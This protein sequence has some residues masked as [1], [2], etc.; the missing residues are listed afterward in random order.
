MGKRLIVAEKKSVGQ[1]I[2]KTLKCREKVD[3]A[4]KGDN[5]IVTWARGHLVELCNPE[6]LDDKY[7]E[8]KSEDLPILPD[9]FRLQVAKDG[10]KQFNI[11]KA[12]MLD[13][14]IDSVVCATDA[15]R[16]GE[17]IFRYIYKLAGCTKPVKR[18]WI[19]SLTYS[20]IK[21][22]F[23]EL[24]DSSEY[25]DLYQ[26]ARCRAEADWLVGMNG[27]RAFAIAN[28]KRGLSVG[29]V[30]SP[31]LAI[32]VDREL[33]RRNFKPEEYC[34]LIIS[35]DGWE[36]RMIN[37]DNNDD[38]EKWSRFPMN[39]KADLQAFASVQHPGAKVVLS[40]SIEE[41]IPPLQL[42]D[43]T[44]LQRDANRLYN[45]SS[46]FTLD[47]AQSLYEKKAITYPRTDSRC[48]SADIK[49]TLSKRL[50]SLCS[51][52]WEDYA[53]KAMH[54]EKDLFGRFIWDKGVSDHHAIIP[55]GEAKELEKWSKGEQNIYDL[56]AR[57]FIG[58]FFTDRVV[59][60]QKVIT[61]IDDK[62]FLSFGEK[63]VADGW[64]AV[65]HSRVSY[66][67]ELPEVN[68]GDIVCVKGLRVRT[69]QTKPPAPHTEASL[70]NAMEHAGKTIYDETLEDHEEEYG[71]GTPATRADIIEKLLEKQMATRKGRALIPTEYGIRLVEILP[72][73]MRSPEMTSEWEARLSH[74]SRGSEDP[75]HFMSDIRKMTAELVEYAAD[76]GNRG[77]KDAN[78][79]GK[80]PLCGQ[81]VRE[82]Q[83]AYYCENKECSFRGIWKAKKGFHP[84]LKSDTMKE[85]LEKGVA[86]TDKG[87]YKII[88]SEP[89]ISFER[90]EKPEP[91]YES[92]WK[93]ITNYGLKPINKV[94]NGGALWFEGTRGD[95]TLKDFASDCTDIGCS[96]Q[97]ANDARALKHKSG[98]YLEVKP[99]HLE[100]FWN[101]FGQKAETN[102]EGSVSPTGSDPFLDL[103]KGSGFEYIDKR[104]K[105]GGLWIVA[106]EEEAK[107]FVKECK[108]KGIIWT[109]A[110]NG[111]RSTKHKPGWY[112]R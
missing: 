68:E 61:C 53:A 18:L 101:V 23:E 8:W 67:K 100:A 55:T 59:K 4:I 83:D 41:A 49:S 99:E 111:S 54:S 5:Y 96:L 104:E 105:K 10:E 45:Y 78:V 12:W 11:V 47:M 30:T 69:D 24:K 34:E 42:Y 70:L 1:E 40:D 102:K 92:L 62:E 28:E 95:E 22:G 64:S 9:L 80:C 25:D 48:L 21:K 98:W 29:R 87:T 38:P 6:D 15:G 93:L 17:L 3:G 66:V 32:L 86:K 94:L 85:L 73:Y 75:E 90:A 91:D 88:S 52:M 76:Q 2:A 77:L 109:F 108:D 84:T 31:T 36:G 56:I 60:R 89:Y 19:S 44:S 110:P 97:F 65:D 74:I 106:G 39:Q 46:K 7:K 103:V 82:Y 112:C 79:V 72:D 33:E 13:P 16:E 50:E 37:Q 26:S 63:V 35:Y 107:Q 81:K 57:R 14:E 51:G 20:A 27:S 71:I 58:M 43:L